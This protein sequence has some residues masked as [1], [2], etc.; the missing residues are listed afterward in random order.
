MSARHRLLALALVVSSPLAVRSQEPAEPET[1][2]DSAGARV[3]RLEVYDR[4]EADGAQS[5]RQLQV[6][7]LRDAA[8]VVAY[9]QVG[10]PFLE[11]NQEAELTRL[12]VTKPDG[13]ELDLLATAPRDVAPVHPP[14][15]P[16]HSDLRLLRAAVPAL[17]VGDRLAFETVVRVRPL[18]ERGAWTEVKFLDEADFQLYELDVPEA[19]ALRLHVRSGLVV[20]TSEERKGGRVV[21]RWTVR[22]AGA[23]GDPP[24]PAGADV[25]ESVEGIEPDV[26]STTFQSWDEFVAWWGGLAPPEVDDAV[27]AKAAEL[28][29]GAADART[30]LLAIHRYVAQEI[31]YL[32]LPL[33]LGR[34]R[35]R[36]PAEVIRTGL[37]DCKDKIRLLASL[38]QAAGLTIEPVLVGV[39]RRRRI[40]D[41]PSPDQFDH[42]VARAR[43]EGADVWMDPTSEMTPMGRL[44]APIRDLPAVAL[45]G[46]P[47]APRAE[48]VTT[49]AKLPV[50]HVVTVDTTGSIEPAGTIRAKVRWSY[51]G[52]DEML[53]LAFRYGTAENHRQLAE[54]L[55]RAWTRKDKGKV[56]A[57][58]SGDPLDVD[59]PFW[60]EYDVE[61]PMSASVWS[62]AWDFWIP[63][64]DIELDEP[65]EEG[66]ADAGRPL[67]ISAAR[68]QRV[69]ARF[70]VPEG[71]AISPPVPFDSKRE[72][73]TYRST[74]SVEGR[75]LSLE[76]E[77][78]VNVDTVAPAQFAEL[79]SLRK[80]IEDDDDQE[81]DIAAA[82]SLVPPEVE[83]A[84]G[85]SSRCWEEN[86]AKRYTAAEAA[87]RRALE[88]DPTVENAWNR[89]GIALENLDRPKDAE[90]AY[91]KQVEVDPDHTHAYANLALLARQE[92]RMKDAEALLRR[93]I[94]VAP[95]EAF[96][97]GRLGDLLMGM[98][99]AGEAE[100]YFARA[101]KLDPDD[102][103]T[104]RS[105]LLIRTGLGHCEEPLA[106]AA[107]RPLEPVALD[108]R[109]SLAGA[110]LAAD[111]GPLAPAAAFFERLRSEAE[112][113]LAQVDA[114]NPTVHQLFAVA[115]LAT[116]WDAAGRIALEKGDTTSAASYLTGAF[117]L[118]PSAAT[119]A[120]R[121][122]VLRSQGDTDGADF[123]LALAA[124]LP[125]L[126]KSEHQKRLEQ[127]IPSVGRRSAYASRAEE[128]TWKSWS[129]N[130]EAP[131]AAGVQGRIWLVYA[132][133]GRLLDAR[134][135]NGDSVA[136]LVAALKANGPSLQLPP[137]NRAH[138]P[139][140][141]T[142]HCNS[143]G[144]CTLLF[145]WMQ[146][147]Y[148]AATAP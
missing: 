108:E 1:A 83:S 59:T 96:A 10:V 135:T 49:P 144:N 50:E 90:A 106:A 4:L 118:L 113:A 137:S 67:E 23:D 71:V 114:S 34:F 109:I 27:R 70:E 120:Q 68:R 31:R 35:A 72:L 125:S 131:A 61:W 112:E 63:L 82:P 53:R 75:T 129:L 85:L 138:I 40:D 110:M 130:V 119:T 123:H 30:R 148:G 15:L 93:Q 86:A 29:S 41:A 39:Q 143:D 136:P 146:G 16:I 13:R 28:T 48:L 73:A 111:C 5:R 65:P 121:A 126:Q 42:V 88:L 9:S 127:A 139:R 12:A 84:E 89:L 94:E 62:K 26:A 57:V 98:W 45:T 133:D 97:Y 58:R 44:P 142:A 11:A 87:C 77:L 55:G 7:L 100:T 51:S 25:E 122:E 24:A 66:D 14:N 21:R 134:S 141:A 102:D 115:A 99:R 116:S 19:M 32:S 52:D 132:P 128:A 33:G 60:I 79:R 76:R 43:I 147:E 104:R 3:E 6:V 145:E 105:L 81:F 80:L 78:V 17:E 22:D 18:V 117:V 103:W 36:P 56:L 92:G 20:E 46:G 47:K 107:A 37:G 8:A 54:L 64:P 91:R 124:A 38:A 69:T 140:R 95:L 2:E 101:V 74:Y